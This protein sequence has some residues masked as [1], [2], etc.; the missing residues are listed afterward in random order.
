MPW[1]PSVAGGGGHWSGSDVQGTVRV[2][3]LLYHRPL[4]TGFSV[5]ENLCTTRSI[6]V[7]RIPELLNR[8][9]KK[10]IHCAHCTL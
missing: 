7:K 4:A 8:L 2:D 9:M 10:N 3:T 5:S 6:L 1:V